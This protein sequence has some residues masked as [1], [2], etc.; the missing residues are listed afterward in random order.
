MNVTH[1]IHVMP[2]SQCQHV[3]HD[4]LNKT[5]SQLTIIKTTRILNT[6]TIPALKS[7]L[8][9]HS[10]FSMST[11][12]QCVGVWRRAACEYNHLHRGRR[13]SSSSD[14]RC[15]PKEFKAQLWRVESR[16]LHHHAIVL[17]VGRAMIPHVTIRSHSF[18]AAFRL[19]E[20]DP[21]RKMTC[22]GK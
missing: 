2:S 21:G 20:E 17:H 10:G 9:T 22:L 19:F 15:I 1:V 18:S 16:I 4:H 5:W 7:F 6:H 8:R 3:P 12:P 11:A 13:R 14:I